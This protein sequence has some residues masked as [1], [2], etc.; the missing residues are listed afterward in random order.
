VSAVSPRQPP[1]HPYPAADTFA[2]ALAE[3]RLRS[4]RLL[5]ALRLGG[6]SVFLVLLACFGWLM[7]GWVGPPMVL[8][9][10]YWLAALAAWW[11]GRTSGPLSEFAGLS[12]PLIDMPA[13]FLLLRQ[14]V[15]DLLARGYVHDAARLAFQAAIYFAGLIALSSLALVA[16]RLYLAVAVAMLLEV[17]LV[18]VA[19]VPSAQD[20]LVLT[21]FGLLNVG[22][23]CAWASRRATELVARVSSEQVRLSRLGRY[24]SPEVAARLAERG[25][26]IAAGE[27]RDATVLFS[28]LRAFTA[29]SEHLSGDR[30]VA[31]LNE[32]HEAMVAQVFEHGGTLD[33]YLGDGLMAYFGAPVDQPEHASRAVRCALGMQRSLRDLNAIRVARGEPA[34]RMGIGVHSGT[35]VVGDVGAASRREF[36]AIGDTVNVAARLERLTKVRGAA[37]LASEETRRLVGDSVPFD[38]G[39]LVEIP[40]REGPMRVYVPLDAR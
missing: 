10:G 39:E 31:M 9:V 11:L 40:G 5:N 20:L 32:F 3:E 15:I 14:T 26:T 36:T 13:V 28:D 23:V 22:V 38:D 33:K 1:G 37:I 12:V 30:V 2:R 19:S 17:W 7:P 8:F 6:V 24:F 35:V 16:R 18:R 25:E 34:L 29:L 21:L 4:A 27:T